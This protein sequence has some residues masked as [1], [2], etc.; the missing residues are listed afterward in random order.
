MAPSRVTNLTDVTLE[1]VAAL[2]RGN[3]VPLSLDRVGTLTVPVAMALARHQG[4]V[5]LNGL[6]TI[7]PD[8]AA[9][10]TQHRAGLSLRGLTKDNHP[11]S[12]AILAENEH[13]ALPEWVS[14]L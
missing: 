7:P 10:L 6:K 2:G 12:I 4:E 3:N 11:Q 5:S 9:A 14:E 1:V 13:I 8:V